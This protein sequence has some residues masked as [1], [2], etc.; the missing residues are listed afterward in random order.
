[1]IFI[2]ASKKEGVSFSENGFPIFTKEMLLQDPPQ[3]I[4]TYKQMNS[5]SNKSKVAVCF[6]Q[7]DE[8]LYSRITSLEHDI[9]KFRKFIG[10]C[11]LDL[12]P[13]IYW[14]AEQQIF[15]ILLNQLY[16]ATLAVNGIKIIP[17]WRIGNLNTLRALNSYPKNSQF[18]VG[19][20]GSVRND[21]I[22]GTFY[23]RAKAM[24]SNPS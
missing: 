17:N 11:G 12:S 24:A 19:T 7:E 15:N 9:P 3:D 5:V 8:R 14:P 6:F 23:T 2:L 18:A 4:V 21:K 22:L 1:M 20:L 16:T 10:V 13:N